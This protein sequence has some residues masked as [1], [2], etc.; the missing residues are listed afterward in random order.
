MTPLSPPPIDSALAITAV[1]PRLKAA[2]ARHSAAVQV[3]PPG[4]GKT[5]AVPLALLEEEWLAGQRILLLA[6]RRLAARTAARRMAAMLGER[7]GRT[8]GY[9]VR[10]ESRV[11][12]DTRVEVVTEGVLTRMLQTDPSLAGVGL[13]IFDEFHER[14]LDADLG[15]AL[16][17]DIQGV[18]NETLRLLVMSATL[19]PVAVTGLLDQAPLIRCDGRA[20]A[21]ETRY[22]GRPA[23]RPLER[24]V[25]D[26]IRQSVAA[27]EGSLLVFLPGA[28]EIRRVDRLLNEGGLPAG[29][30][31]APLYGYLPRDRQDAAIAPAPPGCYKIVLTTAIAETSLTIDGIAVVV[32]SG[33]Q[34][35]A[36]FDPGS[37]M[38]RLVTL[39]VSRASADQRRGRAGRVG[40]GICYRLWTEAT[41]QTLP[42]Y[43]RP[44]ILDAD[45]A[46][47]SLELAAWGVKTPD[48]L[49]WLDPPPAAAFQAAS[50][51][52]M[53]L[54]ALNK[55]GT[56]SRHGRQMAELPL[57]PRLAHMLLMAKKES[58]GGL[59]CRIAAIL[60]ERDP[61]HFGGRKRDADL[62]L[63]LAVL[64][65]SGKGILPSIDE[66]TLDAAATRR[67]L[68]V[69]AML[70]KRLGVTKTSPPTGDPGR[71]LGWA[72]P[73]RI[74]QRRAGTS[75]RFLLANGR[76]AYL[77]PSDPLSASDYLVVAHL[78]GER[79]E[80][81]IFL[82]AA[83]DRHTLL[84]QFADHIHWQESVAWDTRR[85]A[86]SAGRKQKLGTLVLADRP[87]TEP[88]PDRVLTAM[89]E[90]IRGNGL[91][92]LPWNRRLRNWQRRIL[93][94]ARI[95]ADGG[96]WPDVSDAA[97]FGT[98]EAWLAPYL[99][100]IVRLKQLT[101]D[102]FSKAL[103][104]QLTWRQGRLLEE[105]APSHILV[106]SGS[107]LPIDYRRE[108]P[109][110]AVRI[111][112]MLGSAATPAIANGRMPLML[113][114][115]S[116]AGRPAQI[117]RDL[118]GFWQN[119]YAEV[120]RE[121]K[122]RY[123]KHYWPD[124]PLQATPTARVRPKKPNQQ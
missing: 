48:T 42:P 50:R 111:Q 25:V 34:R 65:P 33:L 19:D 113:H 103:G 73:D 56:I 93:L 59:A 119:S 101:P 115:L 74:A 87:L 82:A 24:R 83:T 89:L 16:C 27:G 121:L 28:P 51:L 112:E 100:G 40:P 71:V 76:G 81:R 108:I 79:R 55:D 35:A 107:R 38:T 6:P 44:E 7:V 67:I 26:V 32:D 54:G 22:A 23:N 69:A 61:F 122:G 97:L 58:M 105:L 39:P 18:L 57:H 47:L 72:Y 86:V 68:T 95:D 1:L 123:P 49:G 85:Q 17:R 75:G 84:N 90:G 106:P 70:Q 124:D 43:N 116:P 46:G 80:A 77:N 53:D 114:L 78:D 99:A 104:S 110:L 31:T 4:A 14:S 41:H 37:G 9:R 94:L 13:V 96:P 117:T 12:P 20:F 102:I 21:V 88:V 8:V 15:L 29:W 10:L 118:A 62:R 36:R 30:T 120:K 2:L 64:H 5:T 3:A 92:T 98:L 45:L 63:R 60:S 109:V 91:E 52:L 11:G 66:C